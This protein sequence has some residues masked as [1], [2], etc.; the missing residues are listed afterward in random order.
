MRDVKTVVVQD[1]ISPN[2]GQV[3]AELGDILTPA[4]VAWLLDVVGPLVTYSSTWTTK[5]WRSVARL[6]KGKEQ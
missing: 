3:L 1:I 2:T 5:Q 4:L 6:G